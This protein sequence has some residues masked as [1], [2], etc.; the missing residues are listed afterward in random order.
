[1]NDWICE[2]HNKAAAEIVGDC[3]TKCKLSF[4]SKCGAKTWHA[5]K[6]AVV[7]IEQHDAAYRETIDE[8]PYLPD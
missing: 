7:A 5:P 1:M 6:Q 3:P 4:C 8:D 2:W